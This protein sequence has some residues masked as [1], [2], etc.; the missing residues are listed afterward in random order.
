VPS[1]NAKAFQVAFE[2]TLAKSARLS[3]ADVAL[4]EKKARALKDPD[5]KKAA[6][7]VLALVRHD[8]ILD[9]SEVEPARAALCKL[10]GVSPS[11]LPAALE[12]VLA[13][14]VPVPNVRV[15]D[16][17]LAF[18]FSVDAPSFPAKAGITLEKPTTAARVILEIDPDRITVDSVRAGNKKL[19]FTAR[20]GRLFVDAPLGTKKLSIDYKVTPTDDT[21]GYGLIRD[22]HAG[23]MWT[24]TWPY[25]TGALFPSSSKPDDGA[26][27]RVTV[28]VKAGEKAIGPGASNAQGAFALRADVP[29]YAVA[30]T[31]GKLTDMGVSERGAY[32]ARTVG[33]GKAMS[34]ELRKEVRENTAGAMEFLS[35]WLGPYPHG[36]MLNI[37]E[38]K[39]DYGGMEHAGAIAIGV[40]QAK[41][42]TIEAA[43]HETV[44]HWFGDG[45]HIAHWGE[46]WMSEGFTNFATFRYFE[47]AQGVKEY[48]RLLDAAK[49][50]LRD[51]L[52]GHDTK[53]AGGQPLSN[54][55]HVDPQEGLSWVP[56]MHGVWMLRML[57]V[58]LGRATLDPLIRD[59]YQAKKGQ[60]VTTKDFIEF[61]RARGHELQP[62]FDEWM[63]LD[64]IPTCADKSKIDGKSV[65]L[66][67]KPKG[68]DA[69]P[70]M[71]IPVVIEGARGQTKRALVTPGVPLTV[72]AGFAIKKLTWDPDHTLLVDVR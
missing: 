70:T 46:L 2:K 43:V 60:G 14:A 10:L 56:Y 52:E 42:D 35:K 34:A 47:K 38:I 54:H 40:G 5:E 20:D 6:S 65:T 31:T 15:A 39:S 44:H 68:K 49:G 13:H 50:A 23:R 1:V 72:D 59:W 64:H 26:T 66:S 11:R 16:Y 27:A 55:A 67:L 7:D 48:Q 9:E 4:L 30:F 57:E 3:T 18:D 36:E 28:H 24:L 63:K 41:K 12:K 71:E 32:K 61:A 8:R 22:R 69:L 58:K 53:H 37:V 21:S 45:V 29:A 51:Q 19:T 62:F 25:N 17:D 33:L